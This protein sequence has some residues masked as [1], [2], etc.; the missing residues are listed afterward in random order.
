MTAPSRSA[1]ALAASIAL[2]QAAALAP[3]QPLLSRL[4]PHADHDCTVLHAP[5][6]A[7][8]A[9]DPWPNG[10]I[11]YDFAADV[12][13]QNRNRARAVMND[14]EF[15]CNARFVPRVGNEPQWITIR[16]SASGNSATVGATAG[17][18]VN[19]NAWDSP[20][21]ICHELLHTLG[22]FHEQQRADRD[23][24]VEVIPAAIAPGREGNYTLIASATPIGPYDFDSVSHYPGTFSLAPG[25]TVNLRPRPE[26]QAA[27]ES[28]M[29]D[30]VF[31]YTGPSNGDI[32]A[33]YTIYGGDPIPGPFD[34]ISPAAN[35][36]LPR[37]GPVRLRWSTAELADSYRVEVS[38]NI[39]FRNPIV[40]TV[41][42]AAEHTFI[43]PASAG[44]LFWRVTATNDRGT[45]RP[46]PLETRRL[47]VSA[48][49]GLDLAAP[50]G[51][52]QDD[53]AA[54]LT[55]ISGQ[56]PGADFDASGVID[57]FDAL[58]YL[59]AFDAG[60]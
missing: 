17:G 4:R 24:F 59:R 55:L 40:N 45:N 1:A 11:P 30:W 23:A 9:N 33:L 42:T 47:D 20:G 43:A 28:R 49:C 13:P 10:I 5:G 51:L 37:R 39:A 57:F 58:A 46:R 27:W 12:I 32:W 18:V 50:A 6:R 16:N 41:T 53:V 35:S 2:V 52:D 34:F 22:L 29:G 26:Y 60:C 7:T 14:L 31:N 36:A 21:L 48:A 38:T 15:W 56:S 25:A 54:L 3:A 19:I 44:P 8:S